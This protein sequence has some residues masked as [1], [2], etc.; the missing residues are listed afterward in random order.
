M[1]YAII[2]LNIG[3]LA[4]TSSCKIQTVSKKTP[5]TVI[6]NKAAPFNNTFSANRA[7][8]INAPEAFPNY[9]TKIN[10]NLSKQ[11]EENLILNK[12]QTL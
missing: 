11:E 7:E 12:W 3:I 10:N 5:V 4:L 8:G 1:K 2:I 9:G 6:E